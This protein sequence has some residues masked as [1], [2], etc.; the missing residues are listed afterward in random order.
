MPVTERPQQLGKGTPEAFDHL[1]R[2]LSRCLREFIDVTRDK[3]GEKAANFQDEQVPRT[4][5]T[6]GAIVTVG[7]LPPTCENILE[8]LRESFLSVFGVGSIL[9]DQKLPIFHLQRDLIDLG[10]PHVS[11]GPISG[12]DFHIEPSITSDPC[13]WS[14]LLQFSPSGKAESPTSV[15]PFA[16]IRQHPSVLPGATLEVEKA[17]SLLRTHW[18]NSHIGP[19]KRRMLGPQFTDSNSSAYIMFSWLASQDLNLEGVDLKLLLL[20]PKGYFLSREESVLPSQPFT[21]PIICS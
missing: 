8:T 15:I 7:V 2:E 4:L 11:W 21:S 9:N 19:S 5:D 1:V 17:A 14:S 6:N 18:P 10:S 13:C 3:I 20:H 12:N 16:H